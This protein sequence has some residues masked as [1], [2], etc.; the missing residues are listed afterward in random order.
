[1][2][3]E[4]DKHISHMGL[5]KKN[6]LCPDCQSKMDPASFENY[7][8]MGAKVTI[9]GIKLNNYGGQFVKTTE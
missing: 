5:I 7:R 8:Y 1:M 6:N 9:E 2:V 3:E 4:K